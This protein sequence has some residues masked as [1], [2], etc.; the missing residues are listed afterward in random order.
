MALVTKLSSKFA[1]G[2]FPA[3]FPGAQFFKPGEAPSA[4]E[5]DGLD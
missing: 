4:P 5:D 2:G 1:K 3:G